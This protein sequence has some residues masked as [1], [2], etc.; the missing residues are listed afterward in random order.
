MDVIGVLRDEHQQVM[1]LFRKFDGLSEAN[2]QQAV[3]EELLQQLLIHEKAEEDAVFCTLRE[4][5][6]DPASI[7]AA[8]QE[9]TLLK[10]RI[11][12]VVSHPDPGSLPIRLSEIQNLVMAHVTTEQEGIFPLIERYADEGQRE[13]LGADFK[14]AKAG[15]MAEMPR[16]TITMAPESRVEQRKG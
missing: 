12:E 5:V 8:L 14:T 1:D 7:D 10:Q 4:V 15:H 16:L 13:K 3:A 6:P 2:A 9:Q 11:Q